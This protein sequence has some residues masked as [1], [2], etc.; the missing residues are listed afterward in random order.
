MATKGQTLVNTRSRQTIEFLTTAN[1]SNG[2]LLEMVAAWQPH[3]PEPPE[4][5]HPF[6]K[7][8]FKV[9]EGELMVKQN[10]EITVYRESEMFEINKGVVHAVWNASGKTAKVYWKVKPALKTENMLEMRATLSQKRTLLT[11][12]FS[13]LLLKIKYR[14]ELRIGKISF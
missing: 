12:I 10:G 13:R 11:N 6:Q 4:H 5:F 14:K 8:Y 9:Y 7:E 3:S 1:D 2:R